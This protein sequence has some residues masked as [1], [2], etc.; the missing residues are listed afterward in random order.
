MPAS[1]TATDPMA[2]LAQIVAAAR[3]NRIRR[4][5]NENAAQVCRHLN[6]YTPERTPAQRGPADAT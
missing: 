1:P 5:M 6:G 2:Q 3:A 4:L